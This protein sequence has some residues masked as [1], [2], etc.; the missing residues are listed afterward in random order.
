LLQVHDRVVKVLATTV[1]IFTASVQ[2]VCHS[3][4]FCD[5]NHNLDFCYNDSRV[6][7]WVLQQALHGL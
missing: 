6:I 5:L 3:R 4:C 7:K 1:E 2:E